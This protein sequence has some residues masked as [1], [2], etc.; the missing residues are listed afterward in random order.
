MKERNRR[1]NA[2]DQGRLAYLPRGQFAPRAIGGDNPVIRN[3]HAE[4]Y[5]TRIDAMQYQA[6]SS[7]ANKD[8]AVAL[9][10][11]L[12]SGVNLRPLNYFLGRFD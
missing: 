12:R 9:R 5:Q 1:N 6:T 7:G 10:A 4:V 3:A 2:A 8:A 11:M